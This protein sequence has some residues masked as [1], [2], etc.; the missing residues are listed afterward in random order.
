LALL[1]PAPDEPLFV[2]PLDEPALDDVLEAAEV[3]G[4]ADD[5]LESEL[6]D[7]SLLVDDSFACEP[8]SVDA[9]APA[10]ESVR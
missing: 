1:E 10:R 8:P 5:E 3:A 6:V 4:V 2:E 9:P 7:D